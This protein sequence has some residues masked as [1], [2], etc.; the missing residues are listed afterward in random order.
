MLQQTRVQTVVPYYRR[1]LE[2]F[3]TVH[4]LAEAPLDRVLSLWSGLG[5]YRRARLLHEAA[6]EVA[7]AREGVFPSTAAELEKVRG[8]GRYT[9]GAVASIAFGERAPVVDG[10]VAR[11]LSRLCAL[12]DDV[13]SSAGVARIWRVA[14]ALVSER[15]PGAWNQALMELGSTVCVPQRP[16]CLSCPVRSFCLARE[17]GLEERLPRIAPKAKPKVVRR[18]AFVATRGANVLLARRRAEGSFAG[19]WEPPSLDRKGGDAAKRLERLVGARLG[20]S[21]AAGHVTHVLSHRR[22][23]IAVLSA[24]LLGAPAAM[25]KGRGPQ[26]K[27]DYDAFALVRMDALDDRGLSSLARKLLAVARG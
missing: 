23:E 2:A 12:E 21:R 16:R 13:R 8:I 25:G 26:E 20:P 15:E 7:S 22:L 6:R 10:N 19:M 5:Y 3:P 4:A 24:A 27:G 11:V 9:A 1:F 17:A 18:V 14:G